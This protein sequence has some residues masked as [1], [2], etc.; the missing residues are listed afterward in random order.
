M[1]K[2]KYNEWLEYDEE[3]K[4]EL[5]LI[6]NEQEIEDRF[7]KDLAFGTGGLRGIMGAGT[8]RVNSYTIKKTS[9]GLAN[10]ILN[11]Q[12]IK[13]PSIVIAYDTRN[14]SEKF[15]QD[16]AAIFSSKGIKTFIFSET[17]PTPILSYAVSELE[18][19]A[20]IV[21]TAS[22]NPKEYNGYKVYN[23]NGGQ[24]TPGNAEEV[25][26]EI[27]KLRSFKELVKY[28][29]NEANIIRLNDEI[30]E[31]FLIEVSKQSYFDGDIGV[32]YTPIHGS[33]YKPVTKI[34]EKY[35]LNIVQSQKNPDG[36]F[37]TVKSPNPED[38]NALELAIKEALNEGSDIVL[39]TDPDC[40][41]VGVAVKHHNEFHLLTGNQIGALLVDYVL[42]NKIINN[43]STLLK[44]IVTNELGAEI[45]RKKGLKIQ[46]T[47]TG[48]KYIGEKMNEYETHNENEFVI[49]YEESYGYLVGTHAKD[50][51][52]IVSSMLICE[53][54][55]YHKSNGNTLLDKLDELY[56]DY[57]Y[58][59]DKL[60]S[61]TFKGKFGAERIEDL[62]STSRELLASLLD[63]IS[64]VK[65]YALGIDALPKENVLK[66]IFKD[67]SWIAI[68]PSGTEPK[69]K[70]YYS[71]TAP[72]IDSANIILLKIK[73]Q[74]QAKLNIELA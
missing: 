4:S 44:T 48:F 37:P 6:D 47:L 65:D 55:A 43:K 34:L 13:D 62:M 38:R 60:D 68:R 69:L 28:K 45:A 23:N 26:R 66:F 41:R 46:E 57:G 33:G 20:G 56:K 27:N 59:L 11:L 42:S 18:C 35:N 53:M 14:N 67:S 63:D 29:K 73:E 8:N 3:V 50:K 52:G 9:L 1:Y 71:I 49:G 21:I 72:D 31:K 22:H 24:L 19:D 16:A 70:I 2:V 36:D 7:Y 61:L 51:D 39:G 54:A 25:I 17:M 15:A 74:L 5:L 12:N 58:Y 64:E 30:L 32:T 10:H 40:D